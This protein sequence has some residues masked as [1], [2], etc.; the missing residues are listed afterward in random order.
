[1]KGQWLGD[2]QVVYVGAAGEFD[3]RYIETSTSYHFAVFAFNGPEGFE[4]YLTSSPLTGVATTEDPEIG[5]T[6]ATLDHNETTFVDELTA[7]LN[8]ANYFQIYY[9]NYLSTCINEFY[10]RDTLLG[11]MS[12]NFI[13]CQYSGYD[14]VYPAGFQWWSGGGPAR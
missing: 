7:V 8:P 10:V 13:E 5:T 6:Y 12:Q 14:Y 2:E 1:M 4:N 11:G 3:A 9:S